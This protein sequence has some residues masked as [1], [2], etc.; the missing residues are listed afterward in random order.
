[1]A[2]Q[3]PNN[4]QNVYEKAPKSQ[5]INQTNLFV[6]HIILQTLLFFDLDSR[7][8]AK[9]LDPRSENLHRIRCRDQKCLNTSLRA[10]NE[11]KRMFTMFGKIA[12]FPIN[13]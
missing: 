8:Q 7:F 2:P 6:F 10:Q 12:T 5:K 13:P 1:M 3:I 4:P 11:G 9:E